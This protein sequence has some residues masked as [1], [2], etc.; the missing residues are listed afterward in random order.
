M[1]TVTLFFTKFT[2]GKHYRLASGNNR[3]KTVE[4]NNREIK[5]LHV[6]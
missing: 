4:Q 3:L 6:H 1:E 5:T 2:S